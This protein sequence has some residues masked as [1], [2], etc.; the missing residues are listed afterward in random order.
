MDVGSV[1]D[2]RQMGGG[3]EGPPSLKAELWPKSSCC[4]LNIDIDN[5][6]KIM[7][8]YAYVY[9]L[10]LTL[11]L[12]L[13]LTLTSMQ[14]MEWVGMFLVLLS[15]PGITGGCQMRVSCV[16]DAC[17]MRARCVSCQMGSCSS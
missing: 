1:S 12:N 15:V 14:R 7:S 6:C 4:Q 9:T 10:A 17:Q 11:A 5:D 2:G 8:V 3:R 13:T 16:T